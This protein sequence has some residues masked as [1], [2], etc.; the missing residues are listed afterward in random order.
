MAKTAQSKEFNPLLKI[1]LLNPQGQQ[2]R[3]PA[4]LLFWLF[5]YGRFIVILVE[6]VVIICF[7]I[8]FKLDADLENI[9]KQI[10][11]EVDSIKSH[12]SDELL[13]KQ[14]QQRLKLIQ[15][16][17]DA[18]PDWKNSF[19][20]LSSKV[21]NGVSF[22]TLNL[23]HDPNAKSVQFKISALAKS[24]ND[25]ASFLQALKEADKNEDQRLFKN[26][27]LSNVSLSNNQISFTVAGIIK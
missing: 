23:Q 17:Y 19:S 24:S 18:S 1:N 2:L 16:T 15:Q 3:L 14:T 8:R 5:G 11:T 4:K 26:V 22:S 6:I 21:P 13:I 12:S 10:Q 25:L 9:N 20:N 27:T 7:L